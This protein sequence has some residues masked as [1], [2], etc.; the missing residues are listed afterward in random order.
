MRQVTI[1]WRHLDVD[2]QTCER[3]GDTGNALNDAIRALNCEC[4]AQEV[5]FLLR[6]TP[7]SCA[8]LDQSNAIRIDGRHIDAL[9][10]DTSVGSSD[11]AS[12]ATLVGDETA[13]CRTL[14]Q[15]EERFE[16]I[17]P[18]LIREAACRLVDC[19]G[20]GCG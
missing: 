4:A 11:C 9:L 16:T 2:G 19:C 15:G 14:K 18:E 12:C 3:C 1:E 7:L 20:R 17:P 5:V 10:P 8:D 6:D 13:A